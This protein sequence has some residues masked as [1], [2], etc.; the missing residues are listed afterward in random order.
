M[1]RVMMKVWITKYA[2][3][4]GIMEAHIS[5]SE[6]RKDCL[7]KFVDVKLPTGV[8]D[9]MVEKGDIHERKESAIKKAEDMRQKEI[10]SLKKQIEKL[11]GM[12]F[13]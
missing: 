8:V 3:T 6:L 4:G 12:R 5:K 9:T 7:Y 1:E 13:E 2:L 10:T 11:E